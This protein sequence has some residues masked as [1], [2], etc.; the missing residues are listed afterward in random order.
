MRMVVFSVVM[1]G[2][3][4]TLEF[5]LGEGCSSSMLFLVE[6]KYRVEIS[7]KMAKIV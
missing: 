3:N 4:E 7:L 1:C 2:E 5:S 6:V